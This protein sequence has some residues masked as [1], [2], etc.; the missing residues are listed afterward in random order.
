MRLNAFAVVYWF[1]FKRADAAFRRGGMQVSK[2]TTVKDTILD[3]Q[4][5]HHPCKLEL[6]HP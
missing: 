3:A 5:V 4:Q 6:F 2:K 1:V